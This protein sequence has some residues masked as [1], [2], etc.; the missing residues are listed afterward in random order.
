MLHE[1]DRLE[2]I[3]GRIIERS[4]IGSSHAG[5]VNRLLG[6]FVNLFQDRAIVSVQNPRQSGCQM[7]LGLCR[8]LCGG[9]WLMLSDMFAVSPP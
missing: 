3:E 8:R 9:M 4:P 7:R 6:I 2:L 5:P 1:D